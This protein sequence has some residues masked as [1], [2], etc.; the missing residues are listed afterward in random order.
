MPQTQS[1]QE[2]VSAPGFWEKP[3]KQQI[4]ALSSANPQFKNAPSAIQ[5]S[6]L[7]KARGQ[8]STMPGQPPSP[9][10]AQ[11]SNVGPP[12]TK[13]DGRTS[14]KGEPTGGG[15][16]APLGEFARS[17]VEKAAG[18][19]AGGI[20]KIMG[21][22]KPVT[23][24]STGFGRGL[25]DVG[26][27]LTSPV[28]LGLIGAMTFMPA[29]WAAKIESIPKA[30]K[31]LKWMKTA[32]RVGFSGAMGVQALAEFPELQDAIEKK[33]YAAAGQAS[34][35]ILADLVLIKAASKTG[36]PGEK[37][38]GSK[39]LKETPGTATTETVKMG[40]RDIPV[41]ERTNPEL[42]K[43]VVEAR[44]KSGKK[45]VQP[46][47]PTE[48]PTTPEAI[49]RRIGELQE[50]LNEIDKY[51]EVPSGVKGAEARSGLEAIRRNIPS[52]SNTAAERA[53]LEAEIRELRSKHPQT[54]TDPAVASKRMLAEIDA[55]KAAN[56]PQP[57]LPGPPEQI[58]LSKEAGERRAAEAKAR[59]AA[60]RKPVGDLGY[61]V[62]PEE[63]GELPTRQKPVNEPVGAERP[64]QPPSPPEPTIPDGTQLGAGTAMTGQQFT[65]NKLP[66]VPK[67]STVIFREVGDKGTV[68]DI[69]DA[70][71]RKTPATLPYRDSVKNMEGKGWIKAKAK[72]VKTFESLK[73]GQPPTPP[74]TPVEEMRPDTR[75]QRGLPGPAVPTPVPGAVELMTPERLGRHTLER[76][77]QEYPEGVRG[78]EPVKL[79]GPPDPSGNVAQPEMTIEQQVA[80]AKKQPPEV[81]RHFI[82]QMQQSFLEKMGNV[83]L[84]ELPPEK[85]AA[86]LQEYN[87]MKEYLKPFEGLLPKAKSVGSK[88]SAL[89]P[90]KVESTPESVGKK[91]VGGV[92]QEAMAA[93]GKG[94]QQP[95][96]PA[97]LPEVPGKPPAKVLKFDPSAAKKSPPGQPPSPP[98]DLVKSI[99]EHVTKVPGT[100]VGI[101]KNLL[102][103]TP[104]ASLPMRNWV[105]PVSSAENLQ[106]Q[107]ADIIKTA[108]AQGYKK[109]TV[110]PA[111]SL[112]KGYGE[113]MTFEVQ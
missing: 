29:S 33:D 27:D 14:L 103:E 85:Q 51:M 20:P 63:T 37:R 93:K 101:P 98:V 39:V 108:K 97:V 15:L 41:R 43:R 100:G 76:I 89:P 62:A 58:P 59:A 75:A 46:P 7:Q 3:E 42:A 84:S 110:Q 78:K 54:S 11:Q 53:A 105:K 61:R 82:T 23:D 6:V 79:P 104:G 12:D 60:P 65:A 24:F 66:G 112:K 8:F 30:A 22:P 31:L 2:I 26:V 70:S 77:I 109:I 90:K 74:P 83:K 48:K 99:T 57:V 88:R 49:E 35:K 94:V 4:E 55:A 44:A 69:V 95:Q 67:G 68:I 13:K 1:A 92:R 10:S 21:A 18:F 106:A 32:A 16:M 113:P 87:Q 111:N 91:L 50:R 36:K 40:E 5:R 107:I 47:I 64:G 17:G 56:P 38:V 80:L 9:P 19:V 25:A 73:P 28:N 45:T 72:P 96:P 81:I 102:I 71:G 86:L 52:V 34:A